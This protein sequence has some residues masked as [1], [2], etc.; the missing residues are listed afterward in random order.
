MKCSI[1]SLLILLVTLGFILSCAQAPQQVAE[2]TLAPTENL[3][4]KKAEGSTVLLVSRNGKSEPLGSGFFVDRDK[5]A[6]NIHVVAQPGPIF[7]KL[8][9]NE[10]TLEIV[11]VAAYDV[12]NN[13]V[14]L[15]IAG[16]GK[17]LSIG[18][19]DTVQIDETVSVV[20]YLDGKYKTTT[21]TIDTIQKSDKWFGVE[22][23]IS[24]ESSG[25]PVLNKKGQVM[26]ITVGYGDDSH[27]YAIPSNALK[28]LLAQSIPMEPLTEWQK[29]PYIRAELY[30]SQGEQKYAAKNH[31]NTIVKFNKT[32]KK[33]NKALK[34]NPEHV[35]AYYKSGRIKYNLDNYAG[36]I[37]DYTH[38]IKLNPE[39]FRAYYN[40]GIAKYDINDYAAAIND[41]T[42]AIKLN[43]EHAKVYDNR[44]VAKSDLG[45]SKYNSGDVEK[46]QHLY[47]EAI[48]DCTHA[49]KI[50]PKDADFYNS[51]GVAK[52]RLS[53]SKQNSDDVE[54]AQHLYQEA[55]D[56]WTQTINIDPEGATA[57]SN[58]GIAKSKLGDIESA[59]GNSERAQQLYHEGIVDYGK[60]VQLKY[61]E[62][63]NAPTPR[64]KSQKGIASTVIV[65]KWTGSTYF[66]SGFFVDKD[67][68][69]TNIHVV[70]RP[71]PVYVKLINNETIW[72][73]EEVTA[74][75]V[76]NDI[77]VLKISSEGTPLSLGNS[78]EVQIGDSVVTVGYPS[79]RYKVT[80]GK[81][82]NIRNRDKWIV[83]TTNVF[84]G[85]SG[86]PLLNSKGEVI[87][88]STKSTESGNHCISVPSNILKALL[89]E[90]VSSEPLA[91]WQER[92][93]IRAYVYYGIGQDYCI[94]GNYN[95]ALINFEKAI[96]H[97][98]IHFD[99]YN[100][101]GRTKH[102]L[103]ESKESQGDVVEAQKL[104]KAAIEDYTQTIKIDPENASTFY[105]RGNAKHDL[106]ETKEE[107][108]DIIEAQKLY[109]E[110]IND[111]THAI[112][113]NPKDAEI[114]S[115]RGVAKHDLGETKTGPWSTVEAQYMY[116]AALEDYNRA[117]QLQPKFVHAYSNRGI[118]KKA[119]GQHEAAEKDFAKAKELKKKAKRPKSK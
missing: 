87:G 16:K 101:S 114:Y 115:N 50:D 68:I 14:I 66:G 2:N 117:I 43:P 74:F 89:N 98:P 35:R 38:A 36:A 108:G 100:W 85:N 52:F 18:D 42:H 93:Q 9:D 39:H 75:D 91:Q 69:A 31:K 48:D 58:R 62:D 57:Y 27:N 71:G 90:S 46:A 63:T 17:P 97:Y 34:L 83:T 54:K 3:A 40:R 94:A 32:L 112:K 109:Q 88:I 45:K 33:F 1:K 37:D 95:K 7:A 67:K 51:R 111:Y 53:E 44:G 21:G 82:H 77:V 113:L 55:I 6:T 81:V 23:V 59:S 49:I 79:N 22:G 29:R 96:L 116:K 86:G 118:V 76:E 99:I 106:G 104:Y 92:D 60:S 8:N 64:I 61:T 25:G 20:G 72:K 102:N 28:A 103:G 10:K 30:H 105:N 19:S 41:Y 80:K 65:M 73:V 15:K 47:Q 13:L 84:K 110:A 119:L 26:G 70:A 12:K 24:K 107:Q 5:I 11:G 4:I 56:D 78:A